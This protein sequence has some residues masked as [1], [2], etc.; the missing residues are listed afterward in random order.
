MDSVLNRAVRL[1]KKGKY[2][3]AAELLEGAVL[4]YRESYTFCYTLGLC[5]LNSGNYTA[6][7]DILLRARELKMRDPNVLLALAALY[8]RRA[9]TS[10]A[11]SYY[12]EVKDMDN[13]NRIVK[14]ALQVLKMYGGSDDLIAWIEA[15]KLKK[16]FPNFPGVKNN[17]KKIVLPV[18]ITF[19][20]LALVYGIFSLKEKNGITLKTKPDREGYAASVLEKSEKQKPVELGGVYKIILTEKEILST[21]QSALSL[22]NKNRD[23]AAN[24]E[25]NRILISN[26]SEGIKNKA[27]IIA[28]HLIVPAFND[29]KDNYTY[30]NVKKDSYLY[31]NCYVI[32]KGMAANIT[33]GQNETDFEFLVGYDTR[34]KL[35]GTVNVKAPFAANINTEKPLEILGKIVLDGDA[36]AF[37]LECTAIHQ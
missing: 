10:R 12:L 21:Y 33:A 28:S 34:N 4:N 29:L 16:L 35:E 11:L 19:V 32:W 24:V 27:R 3:D 13:N 15:G 9:D 25:V 31:Q 18:I 1:A 22:F 14:K 5:Y 37:F 23:N 30:E 7:H 17:S 36:G 8:V 20:V 2:T 26:A 6:A